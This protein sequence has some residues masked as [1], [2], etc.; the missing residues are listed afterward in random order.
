MIIVSIVSEGLSWLYES[1]TK[2]L[3]RVSTSR[4]REITWRANA[5]K[6]EHQ[7][8]R[9]YHSLECDK[10]FYIPLQ[11]G[12]VI[13]SRMR[14]WA[15]FIF[16]QPF[17]CHFVHV[18]VCNTILHHTNKRDTFILLQYIQGLV[19]SKK[20]QNYLA[21]G[22]V[23]SFRHKHAGKNR[24]VES[25]SLRRLFGSTDL[26]TISSYRPLLFFS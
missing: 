17:C 6:F 7:D 13:T 16:V 20:F 1:A 4:S 23:H 21:I 10:N 26:P 3:K 22:A 2:F 25:C 11:Y 5:Y 9:C 19:V 14:R 15:T 24:F 12:F 18:N 8:S